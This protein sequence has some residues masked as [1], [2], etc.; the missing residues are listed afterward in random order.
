MKKRERARESE[1]ERGGKGVR[2]NGRGGTRERKPECRLKGI[3][4]AKD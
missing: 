3:G 4:E 2:E 1:R